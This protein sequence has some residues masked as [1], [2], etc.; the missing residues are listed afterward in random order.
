M[1]SAKHV[2]GR[3]VYGG[4]WGLNIGRAGV[5]TARSR[6][7][8]V[9]R[10]G[11]VV[12]VRVGREQRLL[13]GTVERAQRGRRVDGLGQGVDGLGR[14]AHRLGIAAAALRQFTCAH[15]HPVTQLP[16]RH[17]FADGVDHA[18]QLRARDGRQWRHP[19]VG[20][21][22]DQNIWTPDPNGHGF[23][24]HLTRLRLRLCNVFQLQGF[25]T[26]RLVN[27]NNAHVERNESRKR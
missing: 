11:G 19:F 18:G 26:T 13:H 8:G 9:R 24:S 20:A 22:S 25:R 6:A 23:D 10:P 14:H 27:S 2:R 4:G 21:L 17:A 15:Q 12:G 3:R 7:R 16:L 5:V 1:Q